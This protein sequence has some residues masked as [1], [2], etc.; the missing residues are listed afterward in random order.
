MIGAFHQ[1]RLVLIDTDKLRRYRTREVAAGY[2]EVI[3]YGLIRDP[4]FYHWLETNNEKI[5]V[6]RLRAWQK[7]SI[8]VAKTRLK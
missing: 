6:Q 2:A 7:R 3:K 5:V 1:P 8:A 4:D